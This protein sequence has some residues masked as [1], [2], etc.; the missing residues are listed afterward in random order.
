MESFADDKTATFRATREGLSA[1]CDTLE[2]FALFSGL[3]CN[4]DKSSIMYVGNDGPP[5]SD[6]LR[7]FDFQ[8]VDQIKLLGLDNGH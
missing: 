1:I 5:P 6:Y 2:N 3:K 7:D 4:L 8:V